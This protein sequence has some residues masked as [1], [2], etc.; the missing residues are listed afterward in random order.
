MIGGRT[1]LV[2]VDSNVWASRTLRDWLALLHQE[3]PGLY[4]VA[5][6]EDLRAETVRVIRRRHPEVDG[7]VAAKVAEAFETVFPDGR[8]RDYVVPG[9]MPRPADAGDIH[10]RALAEH[11]RADLLVTANVRHLR[12]ASEDEQDALHHE[13]HTADEFFLLVDDSAPHVVRAATARNRDYYVEQA[14]CRGEPV[15]IDLPQ[16]LER[17]GCPAFA[18]RVRVRLQQI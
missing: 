14:R 13:V 10:V 17:A 6:S 7:G 15:D 4:Q 1:H 12:P 9:D 11:C 3:G 5:W 2:V 16:A 18:D 8:V